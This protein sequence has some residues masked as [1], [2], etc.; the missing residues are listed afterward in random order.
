MLKVWKSCKSLPQSQAQLYLK[1]HLTSCVS[2]LWRC[3]RVPWLQKATFSK[4]STHAL[5]FQILIGYFYIHGAL[6][7][8]GSKT[9]FQNFENVTQNAHGKCA[10]PSLGCRVHAAPQGFFSAPAT[11]GITEPCLQLPTQ[12]GLYSIEQK[13]FSPFL[14]HQ[15]FPCWLRLS[16]YHESWKI[17]CTIWILFFIV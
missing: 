16:D 9:S 7:I 11:D 3:G 2:L 6:L 15:C 13:Y 10:N 17:Y 8:K 4:P 5:K 14:I 12:K 1:R